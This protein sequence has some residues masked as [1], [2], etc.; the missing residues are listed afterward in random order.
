MIKKA[1]SLLFSSRK[2]KENQKKE[3]KAIDNTIEEFFENDNQS[4]DQLAP[5]EQKIQKHKEPP[6]EDLESLI[7]LYSEGEFT[8]ALSL[9]NELLDQFPY[10]MDLYNIAGAS[11]AGLRKFDASINNYKQAIKINPDFADAHNNIGNAF[12]GKGELDEA[13]ANYK[14]ATLINPEYFEAYLNLGNALMDKGMQ[15]E[16][17]DNYK[18]AIKINPNLAIA[19]YLIA[20]AFKSKGDLKNAITNYKK[21]TLIYPDYT[22][23][24]VNLGNVLMGKGM[25]D[26][27]IDNYK[28]AIIINPDYAD[29]FNNLGNALQ[30]KG[31]LE[32][33][34]DNYKQAI[35]INPDYAE[36]FNNLG[37][38]LRG[39]SMLDEA[40][41]NYKEAIKINPD[42]ADA[43]CNMGDAL[44]A[45]GRLNEAIDCC[46]KAIKINP[47]YTEAFY[48]MGKALMDR[49]D[50]DKS[51]DNYMKA[52][53]LKPDFADAYLNM[54]NVLANKR[55]PNKAIEFYQHAI[56]INPNHSEAY[57]NQS[58]C[59]LSKEDFKKGWSQ[60]E[61]RWDSASFNYDYFESEVARWD[62]S[63]RGRVLLWAE[64]GVGDIIMFSSII[65]ELY[66]NCEKL[67]VQVDKR[68]IPLY[69]RS[70]PK[71]I[72]YF[73][74]KEK[75]S[76]DLY[77][78][79]IPMGSLPMYFR[80]ERESF[81][82]SSGA[83]LS[84]DKTL[85]NKLLKNIHKD[86][87]DFIVG[88]AWTGGSIKGS[89]STDK[90]I[91]LSE[92]APILSKDGV[93]L[94]N[95]QYGDT[96]QECREL[97][98]DY[99]IKIHNISDIDNFNDLDGLA[100]LIEAC[101][102]IVSIDSFTAQL[103]GALGKS[104]TILLPYSANW[105]WG[106]ESEDS[107]WSSS[108]RLLRQKR[109]SD[110]NF[111]LDELKIKFDTIN[112]KNY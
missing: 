13:I 100:A 39:M 90:S 14:Q 73:S 52:I 43:F 44:Y 70:F 1:K 84:A 31:D 80:I 51:L 104:S 17:I 47:N 79:H 107:Y 62:P 34:I 105:M 56:K 91:K 66:Q 35:I 5:E 30:V 95:L 68:L 32:E 77:D 58:L 103:A 8:E 102:H 69:T 53:K 82:L 40:I 98:D 10:S 72:L 37:S 4:I 112:N 57:F 50:L 12:L 64:Q 74:S 65:Q 106:Y 9:I 48:N 18:E 54:G 67:I 41:D 60:Y 38:A 15:D 63:K 94:V 92:I 59:N 81:N 55:D 28:Q 46:E 89:A 33:A 75:I 11:N 99:G 71:D 88:I 101:D 6:I 21:A 42:Y 83:Y 93:K 49:G 29:A 111:P 36:A 85:S 3:A 97:Q 22:E 16:A 76:E 20:N 26:E 78:S 61:H 86:N 45:S 110:W 87:S 2:N 25:L 108:L 27:A 19:Y 23:A 96:S 109:I 7:N 24:Y